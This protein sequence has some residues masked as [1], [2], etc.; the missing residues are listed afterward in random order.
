[1]T[2]SKGRGIFVT[3]AIKKGKLIAVEKPLAISV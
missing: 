2:A 3:E 1:M